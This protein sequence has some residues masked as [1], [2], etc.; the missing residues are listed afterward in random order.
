MGEKRNELAPCGIYCGACPHYFRTCFGC[1]S[2][3]RE[4]E[5]RMA[6]EVL[7]VQAVEFLRFPDGHLTNN[8]AARKAIVRLISGSQ[9]VVQLSKLDPSRGQIVQKV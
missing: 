3:I 7:G 8:E 5:Q 4:Q 1:S 9:V 6:C 2:E